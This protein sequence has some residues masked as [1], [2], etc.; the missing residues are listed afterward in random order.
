MNALVPHDRTEFSGGEYL[1]AAHVADAQFYGYV[2][3]L[4]TYQL[5]PSS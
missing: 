5:A 4:S 1:H 2:D 3:A